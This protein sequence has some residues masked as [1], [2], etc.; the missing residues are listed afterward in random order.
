MLSLP[1][2]L[3]GM[4]NIFRTF[5]FKFSRLFSSAPTRGCLYYLMYFK[6]HAALKANKLLV[7]VNPPLASYE[8]LVPFI[9]GLLVH[10]CAVM[11]DLRRKMCA[12]AFNTK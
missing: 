11:E 6:I 9:N 2:L 3:Y 10:F 12:W 5:F 8:C 1:V 7:S 4:L